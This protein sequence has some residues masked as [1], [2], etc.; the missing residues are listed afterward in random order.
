MLGLIDDDEEE[1]YI[2]KTS[3]SFWRLADGK[4]HQYSI[5]LFKK[6]TV[7][8]VF[9]FLASYRFETAMQTVISVS[10]MSHS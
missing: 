5:N 4:W 6:L 10:P 3:I 2:R 8:S 9:R 1:N 7:Y